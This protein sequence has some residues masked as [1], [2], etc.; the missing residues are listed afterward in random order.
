LSSLL[1]PFGS[2]RHCT[3]SSRLANL[4][5]SA[6]KSIPIP[7]ASWFD[8]SLASNPINRPSPNIRARC[9]QLPVL[10]PIAT[11]SPLVFPWQAPGYDTADDI[12]P[13]PRAVRNPDA[14]CPVDAVPKGNRTPR[15]NL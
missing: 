15:S 8:N 4:R 14:A 3:P 11:G 2:Y 13:R 5:P 9:A 10:E 7:R 6:A 12:Q 1:A